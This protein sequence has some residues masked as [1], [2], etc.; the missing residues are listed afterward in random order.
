MST[1][2]RDVII[3]DSYKLLNLITSNDKCEV[4]VAEFIEHRIKVAMKFIKVDKDN[5][6]RFMDRMLRCVRI[7][8]KIHHPLVTRYFEHFDYGD[9]FCIVIEYCENGTLEDLIKQSRLTE[10]EAR[11][12]FIQIVLALDYL[13]NHA[14]VIHGD[15][16]AENLVLDRSNNLHIC[17]FGSSIEVNESDMPTLYGSHHYMAP[18]VIANRPYT[19]GADIW[20]LGV[21]LFY[22]VTGE[23]PFVG[24]THD[25]VY[26]KIVYSDVRFPPYLSY[27]VKD[28]IKRM[29]NKNSDGRITIKEIIDHSW[30]SECKGWHQSLSKSLS[31]LA[32]HCLMPSVSIAESILLTEKEKEDIGSECHIQPE[33]RDLKKSVVNSKLY[34]EYRTLTPSLMFPK[35]G[36]IHY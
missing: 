3:R 7:M 22:C 26:R 8:D 29:L 31:N 20:S 35:V 21:L 12:Y 1:L 16:K 13:H 36:G 19:T 6:S 14:R 11:Y 9:Y 17:D 15:L 33:F 10:Q 2:E 34:D 5:Y 4:W 28:L 18:E 23:L 27:H 25:Q 32:H 24:N 30:F